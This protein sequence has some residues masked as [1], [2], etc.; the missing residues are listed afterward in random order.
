ME[1][2]SERGRG[3]GRG[4]LMRNETRPSRNTSAQRTWHKGAE[5]GGG[6]GGAGGGR[7]T[8]SLWVKAVRH[9][10]GGA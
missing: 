4:N 7:K 9:T 6:G 8:K 5:E 2:C 3:R 1:M 10:V